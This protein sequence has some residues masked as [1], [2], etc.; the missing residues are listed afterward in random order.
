MRINRIIAT[1]SA[2]VLFSLA[3]AV[4]SDAQSARQSRSIIMKENDLLKKEI[5]SL[6]LEIAKYQTELQRT[7]SITNEL[8][9][10]YEAPEEIETD[11]CT[12]EYTSEVS[13]SL[14][15]LWYVQKQ[16]ADIDMRNRRSRHRG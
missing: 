8:L 4:P 13:D 12:I 5:D 16:M 1:V 6:K 3:L 15:S 9:K 10:Q 7:D 14:L 2:A 11:T